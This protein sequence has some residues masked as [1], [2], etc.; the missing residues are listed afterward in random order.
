MLT[1]TIQSQQF[2]DLPEIVAQ[3][4]SKKV[5]IIVWKKMRK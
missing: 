5:E 4:L 1:N 3:L 2:A